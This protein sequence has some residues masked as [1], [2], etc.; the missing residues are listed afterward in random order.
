MIIL[1]QKLLRFAVPLLLIM[2]LILSAYFVSRHS[3]QPQPQEMRRYA[4]PTST[5]ISQ[6]FY[7]DKPFIYFFD[8]AGDVREGYRQSAEKFFLDCCV[9]YPETYVLDRY[10]YENH[11]DKN[12]IILYHS[13][14]DH[15]GRRHD[16]TAIIVLQND[17]IYL[18]SFY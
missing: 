3:P 11:A 1:W 14:A 17:N 15:S 4:Q 7:Q 6:T 18:D 2:P 16:Q 13:V 8:L 12:I 9:T 10:H 5:P